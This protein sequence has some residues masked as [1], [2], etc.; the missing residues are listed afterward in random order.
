MVRSVSPSYY[1]LADLHDRSVALT[2]SAGCLVEAYDTDSCGQTQL[3]YD[4]AG[5]CR[6][7]VPLCAYIYTGRRYDPETALTGEDPRPGLYYYRARYYHPT[8]GRFTA[9]DPKGYEEGMGLYQY[10]SGNP[11]IGLDA[12]GTDGWS[13]AANFASAWWNEASRGAADWW[14]YTKMG[15]ADIAEGHFWE[16]RDALIEQTAQPYANEIISRYQYGSHDIDS[17]SNGVLGITNLIA[18]MAGRRQFAKSIYNLDVSTGTYVRDRDWLERTGEFSMGISQFSGSA[19]VASGMTMKAI[20]VGQ[21]AVQA[22]QKIPWRIQRYRG[23]GGGGINKVDLSTGKRVN[24]SV[25][26]GVDLHSTSPRPWYTRLHFHAAKSGVRFGAGAGNMGRLLKHAHL[27][28][29]G[30]GA[31]YKAFPV[32][33]PLVTTGAAGALAGIGYGTY[34]A[35]ELI[36]DSISEQEESGVK[37]D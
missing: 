7:R 5:V 18:D 33:A 13:Y 32:K 30:L 6:K 2:C 15:A 14:K 28:W 1:P 24:D 17:A 36:W 26:T 8:L 27:P 9:R 23:A 19:A 31:W 21:K 34:K 16:A 10:T 29:E 37:N 12:M 20:N 22:A 3:F 11:V 25:L 4:L 35:A